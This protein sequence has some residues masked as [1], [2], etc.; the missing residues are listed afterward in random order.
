MFFKLV[1]ESF[2]RWL[3][4]LVLILNTL[5]YFMKNNPSLTANLLHLYMFEVF[6]PNNIL[7]NINFA[8]KSILCYLC[9]NASRHFKAIYLLCDFL[10]LDFAEEIFK[11]DRQDDASAVFMLEDVVKRLEGLKKERL[12]HVSLILFYISQCFIGPLLHF[13]LYFA[14]YYCHD[15]DSLLYYVALF[16]SYKH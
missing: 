16:I 12:K 1:E 14:M 6:K 8:N 2:R 10:N 3:Y 15:F 13:V 5:P 7:I 4:I 11:S 9:Q